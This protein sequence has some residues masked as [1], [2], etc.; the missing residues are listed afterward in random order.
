MKA[1]MIVHLSMQGI[2]AYGVTKTALLG[3]TKALATSCAHHGVRVNCIAPG[4]IKTDFSKAVRA[5]SFLF[6]QSVK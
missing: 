2:S 1:A 3:L 6:F 5:H 4:I